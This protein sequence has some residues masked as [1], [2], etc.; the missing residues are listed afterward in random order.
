MTVE[1]FT[2]LVKYLGISI[3][4]L[5]MGLRVLNCRENLRSKVGLSALV[6]IFLGTGAYFIREYP[7]GAD[8]LIIIIAIIFIKL[9]SKY[10]VEITATVAVMSYAVSYALFIFST[11]T[12]AIL[13]RMIWNQFPFNS[14]FLFVPILF[15][16]ASLAIIPFLFKRLKNGLTFLQNTE[17]AGIGLLVSGLIIF[18]YSLVKVRS[19]SY[20]YYISFAVAAIICVLGIFFWWRNYLTKLYLEKNTKRKIDELDRE[21]KEK[22]ALITELKSENEKLSCLIHRDNKIIPA[23]GLLVKNYMELHHHNTAG[24][25]DE[26]EIILHNIEAILKDR[27]AI[28][29]QAKNLSKTLPDVHVDSINGIFQYMYLRAAQHNIDYDVIVLCSIK[30]LIENIITELE[31]STILSDMIENAIIATSINDYKKILITISINNDAYEINVQDSGVL[32][33]KE[34]LANIGQRRITSHQNAGGSGIGL[35]TLFE[36]LKKSNASLHITE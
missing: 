11:T 5:Y 16:Q 35:M 4:T 17:N 30:Y 21:L 23:M 18:L 32:F 33:E 24:T 3:C 28:I 13:T 34:I 29:M 6:S 26:G 12:V 10:R 36:I 1:S 27:Y 9:L 15:F 7:F 14:L 22:S 8:T 25:N 31:L 2:I 19:F 20:A